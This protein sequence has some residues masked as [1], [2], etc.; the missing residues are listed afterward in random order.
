M[1]EGDVI[2]VTVHLKQNLVI[3]VKYSLTENATG[4]FNTNH[5][6]YGRNFDTK[7]SSSRGVNSHSFNK[8]N[9]N[10]YKSVLA[11]IQADFSSNKSGFFYPFA[12]VSTEGD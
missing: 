1:M 3:F 5:T 12:A 8:S 10:V 7:G 2:E 4:R 6:Y 11:T 9:A